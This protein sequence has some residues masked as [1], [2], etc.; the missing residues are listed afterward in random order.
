MT[1]A[2]HQ[3]LVIEDEP[4]IRNVLRVL[5]EAEGYR[6][7]EADTAMR[8]EIEARSHKPD[9]LLVDLGLPDGDGLKVIRRVRSW[10]PV[11]VIV[12]SARTME[13]QKIAALDAGADDYI[14]KPFS[15]P[16]LLARVRAALRRNVRG[17]EQT[18]VLQF[19]QISVNLARRETQGPAGEIHLTPLEYRV[20]ECLARHLGSIVIQNQ[21][22]REVWG[23]ERLGDTRSLRVS[24]KNLR[25]KL[26][27]DPRKP[28]YLVTEAGLGYRLRADEGTQEDQSTVAD[29][30]GAARNR[31]AT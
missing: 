27:P 14:T 22:V 13:E 2:M 8:A 30:T 28:R 29:T 7:I 5:L 3:I 26:E 4:A 12:L 18:S 16:E 15:A 11:P 24:V 23:P 31:P 10:S 9:L 21:L 20:L 25:Y 6:F 17:A 19:S 1:Q